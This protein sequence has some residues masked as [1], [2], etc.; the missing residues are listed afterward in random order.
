MAVPYLPKKHSNYWSELPSFGSPTM[1]S[2]VPLWRPK[3]SFLPAGGFYDF[4]S[5]LTMKDTAYTSLALP[6]HTDNTYFTD[7]S[8]LQMFHLLSHTSGT[9]G[10]SL[11]VDGFHCAEQLKNVDQKAYD[12]LSSAPI[13]W[14]ASGNKGITITPAKLYPVFNTAGR[15]HRLLQIRWNNDDRAAVPLH[16]SEQK[17]IKV[18]DW[19]EAAR[20]WNSIIKDQK[21][22][23]WEQ[24]VP[25]RPLSMSAPISFLTFKT[26]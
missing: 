1:V 8:G 13:N 17:G 16:L 14:H 20:L 24:L 21:N 18:D 26:C 2:L 3:N 9:G 7:P 23:Y 4:T 11:L 5:D 22:E 25:R 12:I 15:D 10:S 19:Y 6:A